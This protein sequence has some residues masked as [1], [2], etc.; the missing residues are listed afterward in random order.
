[1][2]RLLGYIPIGIVFKGVTLRPI[3][4]DGCVSVDSIVPI[5]YPVAIG[6]SYFGLVPVKI[7]VVVG[8]F[9][10]SGSVTLN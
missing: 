8:R 1:M 9:I 5:L 3:V 10:E 4:G 7:V 6:I 2:V